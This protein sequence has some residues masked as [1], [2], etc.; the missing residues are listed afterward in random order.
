MTL[1]VERLQAAREK[2]GFSLL[3]AADLSGVPYSELRDFEAGKAEPD[4]VDLRRLCVIYGC[5]IDW[6][7]GR[8]E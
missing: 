8:F 6:L 2:S 7:M 3:E 1:L 5:S 4:S